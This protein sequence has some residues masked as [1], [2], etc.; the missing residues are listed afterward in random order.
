[1][2]Q[3]L[4]ARAASARA[5]TIADVAASAGVGKTSVS[6]FLN[7]E[8][9]ILSAAIRERIGAAIA[10]LGYRPSQMARGLRAGRTRLVGMLVADLDNPYSV[11]VMGGVEAACGRAGLMPVLCNAANASELERRYLDLLQTYRVDGVIVNP[12]GMS[13][14]ALRRVVSAG[15][16]T[17]L[18]D[19]RQSGLNCDIVGLDNARAASLLAD[20]LLSS[21][22]SRYYYVTGPHTRISSRREREAALRQRVTEAGLPFETIVVTRADT[23][24]AIDARLMPAFE[25]SARAR[26]AIVSGNG[27]TMLLVAL[28]L[29]RARANPP[30]GPGGAAGALHPGLASFDEPGWLPLAVDGITTLRQPTA[31]IGAA[32]VACL[33]ER[34]GG[35]AGA[36]RELL[37]D[38]VL[39]VRASTAAAGAH[40]APAARPSRISARGA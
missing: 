13:G 11:E 18:V 9:D 35:Y 19:R 30:A 34:I 40:A 27:Q 15:T 39:T 21:G 8:T 4:S 7:G 10:E 22:F 12:V 38:A 32:A 37:F 31:D 26:V 33:D 36:P 29:Q 1:M 16:P 3:A 24:A 23:P 14:T 20:H 2:G 6:R 5:P 17:V 25:A 28:A